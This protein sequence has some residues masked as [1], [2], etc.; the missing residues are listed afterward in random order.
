MSA[1]SLA[2][3]IIVA[4][5]ALCGKCGRR[6]GNHHG[7]QCYGGGKFEELKPASPEM[8]ELRKL[9]RSWGGDI[10]ELSG[11]KYREMYMTDP[12]LSAAP[13]SSRQLGINWKEKIVYYAGNVDWAEVIHEMGHI[14]ACDSPPDDVDEEGFFGWEF[15]LLKLIRGDMNVW[16]KSNGNYRLTALNGEIMELGNLN[17]LD[18]LTVLERLVERGNRNGN[19]KNGAPV[20][21]R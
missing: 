18:R 5:D 8:A 20:A 4:L 2:K 12:D 14:F 16:L 15:R 3:D 11:E 17:D 6:F 10:I 21:I 7:D 1:Q 9:A 13:F 19:I